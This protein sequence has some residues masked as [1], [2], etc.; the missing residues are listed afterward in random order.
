VDAAVTTR[1]DVVLAVRTADCVPVLFAAPGGVGAAHAGWRGVVSGVAAETL[2]ALCEATGADPAAVQ[3]A[4]GPHISRAVYE[5]GPEVIDALAAAD[6]QTPS[7][8]LRRPGHKPHVGLGAA[9]DLQLRRLGV[10][11]IEHLTQCTFLNPLFYSYRREGPG[12]GRQAAVIA[13]RL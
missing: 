13:R 3:V 9:L 11:Q 7:T 10:C 6:L 1:S 4:V 5:V 2:R 12:T 8:V